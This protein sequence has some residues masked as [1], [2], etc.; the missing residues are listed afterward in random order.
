MLSC[1]ISSMT[2]G[3]FHPKSDLFLLNLQT[4]PPLPDY[5]FMLILALFLYSFFSYLL[6]SNIEIII[7]ELL[8]FY[9][10]VTLLTLSLS[11]ALPANFFF[12]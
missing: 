12:I 3:I 4:A 10:L 2:F 8:L 6:W 5:F 1:H 9:L 11:S 7:I